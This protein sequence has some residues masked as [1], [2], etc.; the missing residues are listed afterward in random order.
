MEHR[1]SSSGVGW[2]C[3]LARR[4]SLC[5]LIALPSGCGGA[6]VGRGCGPVETV[7]SNYPDS[8]VVCGLDADVASGSLSGQ[9]GFVI[10]SAFQNRLLFRPNTW[11]DAGAISH[12]MNFWL[13][14][15]R[16]GCPPGLTLPNGVSSLTGILI[17]T[18]QRFEPGAFVV[19]PNYTGAPRE[20]VYV[21]LDRP[22]QKGGCATS[23]T[24]EVTEVTACSLSGMIDLEMGR[25][26]GDRP[27]RGSFRATYCR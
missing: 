13:F 11:D 19:S 16:H 10:R 9:D 20:A 7:P 23:G 22:P 5:G 17:D 24:I 18:S 1:T 6:E 4:L 8:S 25:Y 26:P 27:L 15:D 21:C 14:S 3:G 2:S 12:V